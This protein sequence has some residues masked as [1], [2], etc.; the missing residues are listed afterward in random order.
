MSEFFIRLILGFIWLLHG[1]PLSVQAVMGNALGSLLYYLVVPRRR[2]V[3][4]N[5]RLCF[6]ELDERERRALARRHIRLVTR[7]YLER[8][9]LWWASEERLQRLIRREGFEHLRDALAEGHPVIL[10]VPHF[11]GL[12]AGGMG[13]AMQFK[14]SSMYS[15]QRSKVLDKML[16]RGRSRFNAPLLLSRQ[17]G[18]RGA[19]KAMKKGMPFFYLPDLDFGASDAV[20]VPFFG[21]QAA[22]ITGLSRMARL[23]KAKVIPV[24]NEILP[25]GEGYVVRMEPPWED[26]PT[27]DVEADTRRMNAWLESR[28]Q[29]MPE[30]YYWVHRRFKTRPPGEPGLY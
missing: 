8:G 18:L 23:A 13:V 21:V 15:H 10:L 27:E 19:V 30:Q 22:T 5:L 16:L 25:G 20:F 17:D 11:I 14:A 6:P 12:D 28:V 24:V 2:V 4:T 29:T 3:L 9:I 1:L 26:F 7:S